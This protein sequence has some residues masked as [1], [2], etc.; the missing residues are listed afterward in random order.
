MQGDIDELGDK[1]D[2]MKRQ[3]DDIQKE[4]KAIHLMIKDMPKKGAEGDPPDDDLLLP[5]AFNK[6][7][8]R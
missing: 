3:S 8:E 7:S 6:S 5:R 4:I 2:A 1:V